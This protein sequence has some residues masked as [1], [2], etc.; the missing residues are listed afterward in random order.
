MHVP[1]TNVPLLFFLGVMRITMHHL[2]F[3]PFQNRNI[4]GIQ[5]ELNAVKPSEGLSF[6]EL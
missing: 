2:F 1:H 4:T 5:E 3:S 6:L